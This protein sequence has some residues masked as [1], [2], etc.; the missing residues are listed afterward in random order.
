MIMVECFQ[1]MKLGLYS[2]GSN[3]VN[4][5]V[6]IV[7]ILSS[8]QRKLIPYFSFHPVAVLG[9]LSSFLGL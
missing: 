5:S 1:D 7:V 3:I 4:T 9:F 6:P 2:I 8:D